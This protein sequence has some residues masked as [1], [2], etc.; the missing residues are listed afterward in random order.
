V[1]SVARRGQ[2]VRQEGSSR[3]GLAAFG[4]PLSEEFTEQRSAVTPSVGYGAAR[5]IGRT[6]DSR[7]VWRGDEALRDR[8]GHAMNPDESPLPT[9]IRAC[10]GGG[11]GACP[12]FLAP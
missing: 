3:C 9:L 11:G 6:T 10:G 1:T 12:R 2:G 4:V 7:G 5:D 8:L